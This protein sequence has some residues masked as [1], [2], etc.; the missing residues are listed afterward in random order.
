MILD[1]GILKIYKVVPK[2]TKTGKPTKKLKHLVD[3]WYGII[4]T[5]ISEYYDAKQADVDIELRVEILQ[6]K[7]V[8]SKN[9]IVIDKEQYNVG[10]VYHGLDEDGIP[11]TDIT[12]E[13]VV[14]KI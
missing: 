4:N 10:R 6:N 8:T 9:I 2:K 5:S 12:L 1:D 13:K 14:E 11:I 3:A 7:E